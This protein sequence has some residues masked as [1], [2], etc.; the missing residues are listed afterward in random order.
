MRGE[1]NIVR[2]QT[3]QVHGISA[4]ILGYFVAQNLK[5]EDQAQEIQ[6]L[7][8]NLSRTAYEHAEYEDYDPLVI[9][10]SPEDRHKAQSLLLAG[11]QYDSM[12]DRQNRIVIAHELTFQW[13]FHDD[14][15]ESSKSN[16]RDWSSFPKWLE[17]DEQ[18]YWITGKAGSGKS[19]LMKFL[20][21]PTSQITQTKQQD[22]PKG[23]VGGEPDQ[24]GQ[25]NSCQDLREICFAQAQ[26]DLVDQPEPVQDLQEITFSQ[27]QSRCH[28][29]LRRWANTS[30]LV[31]ASFYF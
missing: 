13:V 15:T 6:E 2:D 17:S 8:G 18:V 23:K 20:C 26:S 9:H 19:T 7:Q 10:L 1:L 16:T 30:R 31:V 27:G 14:P 28:P 4:S 21:S 25:P 24:V 11:I 5:P 29:Y 22:S 3:L 12:I